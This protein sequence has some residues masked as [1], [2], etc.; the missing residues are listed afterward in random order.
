MQDPAPTELG[1]DEYRHVLSFCGLCSLRLR[2]VSKLFS[3]L[4]G[5]PATWSHSRVAW[6]DEP[7]S[8]EFLCAIGLAA[9]AQAAALDTHDLALRCCGSRELA[10]RLGYSSDGASF[11]PLKDEAGFNAF[12][13]CS[14]D[15]ASTPS[16]TDHI[17]G[18]SVGCITASHSMLATCR[19]APAHRSRPATF[20]HLGL[21]AA[22]AAAVTRRC[23]SC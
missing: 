3:R 20:R 14:S 22:A 18:S 15:D 9:A 16:H 13:N 11:A 21:A 1:E 17:G 23:L 2:L 4:W 5:D 6:P 10:A 19:P 8:L 7:S 12:V